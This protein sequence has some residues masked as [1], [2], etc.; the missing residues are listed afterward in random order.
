MRP[1]LLH[2]ILNYPLT[3]RKPVPPPPYVDSW[4]VT[5]PQNDATI[6]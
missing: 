6:I 5:K 2:P 4:E 1:N 3:A